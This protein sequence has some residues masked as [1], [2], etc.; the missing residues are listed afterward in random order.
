MSRSGS[1]RSARSTRT[2]SRP[3]SRQLH[4]APS[5]QVGREIGRPPRQQ[6]RQAAAARTPDAD[7]LSQAAGVGAPIRFDQAVSEDDDAALSTRRRARKPVSMK[8]AQVWTLEVENGTTAHCATVLAS[9]LTHRLVKIAWLVE[10]R[11]PRSG[12]RLPQPGRV[13]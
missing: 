12:S 11:V 7:I 13:H 9:I 10:F 1:S 5:R 6:G 8:R 4:V 3:S 2:A